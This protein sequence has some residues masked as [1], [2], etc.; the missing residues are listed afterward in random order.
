MSAPRVTIKR[1]TLL[2]LRDHLIGGDAVTALEI[3]DECLDVARQSE[4]QRC[5][6]IVY[7]RFRAGQCTY[8]EYRELWDYA[9]GFQR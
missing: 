2:Q 7:A 1:A 3:V 8:E 4:L 5:K 6:N 9:D